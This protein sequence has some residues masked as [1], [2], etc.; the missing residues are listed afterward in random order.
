M[1]KRQRKLDVASANYN[2]L[3]LVAS[4]LQ[5]RVVRL[6]R[7]RALERNARTMELAIRAM[8]IPEAVKI[9]DRHKVGVVAGMGPDPLCDELNSMA[10]SSYDERFRYQALGARL[11]QNIRELFAADACLLLAPP[12]E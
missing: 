11:C 2:E 8:R 9:W 3:E 6:E 4:Q 10:F 12:P 1:D 5:D 7:A